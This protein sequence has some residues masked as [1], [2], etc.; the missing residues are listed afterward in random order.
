HLRPADLVLPA[1]TDAVAEQTEVGVID[2]EDTA[3]RLDLAQE[4]LG[5]PTFVADAV[6]DHGL[7]TEGVAVTAVGRD[8]VA[9]H[10]QQIVKARL[11]GSLQSVTADGVVIADDDK[12][13]ILGF[14]ELVDIVEGGG[15]VTAL[16]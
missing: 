6:I 11:R 9:A 13:E 10:Q 3:R 16:A 4:V 8:F 2:R 7:D 5:L 1:A 14:G 15:G 12:I